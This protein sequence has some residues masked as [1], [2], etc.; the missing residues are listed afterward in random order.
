MQVHEIHSTDNVMSPHC[1]DRSSYKWNG[2]EVLP[3]DVIVISSAWRANPPR[4]ARVMTITDEPEVLIM[5][6]RDVTYDPSAGERFARAMSGARVMR[7]ADDW[8]ATV[9][10]A[11]RLT[12]MARASI[13][14]SDYSTAS[15]P[16]IM[17]Y[18]SCPQGLRWVLI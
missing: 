1:I 3:G 5:K 12:T 18:V 9:I 4:I 15:S 14:T 6:E 8:M 11:A 13:R 10:S 16:H 7:V 17:A 2:L